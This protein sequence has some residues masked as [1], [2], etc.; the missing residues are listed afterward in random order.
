MRQGDAQ[1]KSAAVTPAVKDGWWRW[2]CA[3][4]IGWLATERVVST[5]VR[6]SAQL[7]VVGVVLVQSQDGKSAH[8][9]TGSSPTLGVVS[10]LTAASLSGFA[11][12]YLEKMFTSGEPSA[13]LSLLCPHKALRQGRSVVGRAM[14]GRTHEPALLAA[15]CNSIPEGR[16]FW[17]RTVLTRTLTRTRC[18]WDVALAT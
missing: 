12:V 5:R 9:P 7:L 3:E 4:E 6:A 8:A 16:R 2:S 15:Y 1:L 13:P 14:G 18:R 10:A 11:G 17:L